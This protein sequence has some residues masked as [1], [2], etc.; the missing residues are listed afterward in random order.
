MK[1][2]LLHTNDIHSQI[3]MH[4]QLAHEL[5]AL[6]AQIEA[7]GEDVL[8]FD[9]GDTLDRVR[10]ETEATMGQVNAALLNALSVDGW[11]FGNN[12]GLTIAPTLWPELVSRAA[13]TTFGTNLRQMSGA[14]FPFFEDVKIFQL[15]G[16][17]LGVFGLTPSYV[18][19]YEM[20]GV[21]ALD[22]I[23]A[24]QSAVRRLREEGCHVVVCL[25]HLGLREDRTLAE[26]VEGIDVIL[27]GH[28]HQFMPAAERVSKTAIFQPGKHAQVFG[29]TIIDYDLDN[30]TLCGV[31]STPI[32]VSAH[33]TMDSQLLSAYRGYVSDIQERLSERVTSLEHPLPV[34]YDKESLFA[35]FVADALYQTFPSD[36][37]MVASGALTAS[38][39]SGPI[40]VE[41]VLGACSTPTRPLTLTLLGHEIE[42]I[43]RRAIQPEFY[44]QKGWGFGFRGSVVGYLAL[45]NMHVVL[46][47][48]S[49]NSI[50][51]IA[52]IR[53]GNEN[54]ELNRP[55]RVT[56]FEYLWLSPAY[57]TFAK[58]RDI[59]FYEP[60]VREVILAQLGNRQLIESSGQGR[61]HRFS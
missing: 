25:S 43:L 4:M 8:T 53:V 32:P 46:E 60:L 58:G 48:S 41:H 13:T 44:L 26:T 21:Q 11:V 22:P 10:P 14:P 17:R 38:L 51:L 37:V 29:H 50:P 49:T 45:S 5:R 23:I 40:A 54:L 55:Y 2:H 30:R 34:S 7:A 59:V 15:N 31:E 6:R 18:R 33:G 24:A 57:P 9:I 52:G 35:N 47:S 1:V 56:T 39:R 12:E 36:V 3:E 42:Q 61:Y 28:T 27:G 19:P 16:L 20:L